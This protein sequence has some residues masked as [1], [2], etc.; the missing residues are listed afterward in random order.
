MWSLRATGDIIFIEVHYR[1]QLITRTL[2]IFKV[3]LE[4]RCARVGT[5]RRHIGGMLARAGNSL[6]WT[7]A[8]GV[9]VE[10][11]WGQSG[12]RLEQA[13]DRLGSGSYRLD[14]GCC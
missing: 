6:G 7:R 2:S 12:D 1:G 9:H 4:K 13:E 8:V 11:D 14:T 3:L 5:V 10:K